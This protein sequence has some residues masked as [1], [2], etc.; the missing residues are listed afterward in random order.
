MMHSS[1][2]SD[3]ANEGS[4]EVN[5][6]YDRNVDNDISLQQVFEPSQPS[7]FS[8]CSAYLWGSLDFDGM[9]GAS[10]SME[11]TT[12][13]PT[14][15]PSSLSSS[16]RGVA[17]TLSSDI[18]D[19]KPPLSLSS[20]SSSSS[21]SSCIESED[22]ENAARGCPTSSSSSSSISSRV[23]FCDCPEVIQITRLE[24]RFY[25]DYFYSRAELDDMKFE[26]FME[27]QGMSLLISD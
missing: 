23:T 2:K 26:K 13:R 15:D 24:K 21:S 3:S 11:G 8:D 6:G 14:V 20:S 9:S 17:T 27:D 4:G 16:P 25:H 18:D 10:L 7:V 5:L 19:F 22:D 1:G 12:G